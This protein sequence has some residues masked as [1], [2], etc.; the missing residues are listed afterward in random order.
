VVDLA[1]EEFCVTRDNPEGG[2]FWLR[3]LPE[4]NTITALAMET[5]FHLHRLNRTLEHSRLDQG[6]ARHSSHRILAAQEADAGDA[7]RK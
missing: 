7:R 6:E 3:E 2:S 4:S 1:A 5:E